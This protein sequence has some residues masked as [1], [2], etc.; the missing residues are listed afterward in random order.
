MADGWHSSKSKNVTDFQLSGTLQLGDH[1]YR[2]NVSVCLCM[3]FSSTTSISF[4]NTSVI[5]FKDLSH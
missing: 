5:A 1:K 3:P 4:F 2:K